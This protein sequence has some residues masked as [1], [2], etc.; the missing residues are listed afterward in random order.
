MED[1][2]WKQWLF[3]IVFFSLALF[4][5]FS[6]MEGVAFGFALLFSVLGCIFVVVLVCFVIHLIIKFVAYMLEVL[7]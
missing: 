5:V 4:L 2:N 6:L 3:L 7:K 1:L